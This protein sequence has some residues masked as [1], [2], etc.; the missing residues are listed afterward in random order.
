MLPIGTPG[1]SMS[2]R[3]GRR[4]IVSLLVAAGLAAQAVPSAAAA[5]CS[6]ASGPLTAPLVELFT[7]E[8]CDSCPP[9]D[10]WLAATFA[11]GAAPQATALAFHVDY[12]DRLGWKDR[13]AAAVW[14]ERQRQAMRAN[15]GRFVYTPQV[16]LQGRDFAWRDAGPGA[17][18]AAAAARAPRATIALDAAPRSGRV[19]VSVAATIPAAA[20][21]PDAI[22]EL[23]YA[24][25]GLVSDVK[26]GENAGARLVHDHV[27][28]ALVPG[29]AFDARGEA[30]G[31]VSLPRPEEAGSAP[32][33]VALVRNATSGD[34]LQTL[35][36]PLAGAGCAEIR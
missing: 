27:V 9:A 3:A 28:R 24:D 4:R 21:R 16:L 26:A 17:A 2:D 19:A 10:R 8:G 29:P 7:S 22:V 30:R 13:F 36:L 1:V 33:V 12:W 31:T 14:T 34:V 5:G 18:I 23:A 15:R 32:A 20:D 11:P 6:A 25:S 35:V